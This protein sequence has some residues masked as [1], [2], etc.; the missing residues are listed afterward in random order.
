MRDR[1]L[2]YAGLAVF[3][4]MITYPIWHNVAAGASSKAPDL[5]L[6]VSERT[7]IAPTEFMRTSHMEL[8]TGW[9]DDVVR[10]GARVYTASSGR[11][12]NK[13]L[14]GTCLECHAGKQDFCDRCHTYAAVKV[15]CWDCHTDPKDGR[16][17]P[18]VQAAEPGWWG[19]LPVVHPGPPGP[20]REPPPGPPDKPYRD[21]AIYAHR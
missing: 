19:D 18:A 20:R 8:L 17:A 12:F 21:G 3:L 14:S 16:P 15:Y 11:T 5:K 1:G 6:P 9:R 2:I 4:G 10:R 13:S 7:C